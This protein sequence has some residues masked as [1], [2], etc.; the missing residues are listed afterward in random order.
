MNVHPPAGVVRLLKSAD[1]TIPEFNAALFSL[2]I[3]NY[4][5]RR[6]AKIL[7]GEGEKLLT[8]LKKE[9]HIE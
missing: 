7:I 1:G 3:A 2:K 8:T 4:A 6:R 5:N 9:Y